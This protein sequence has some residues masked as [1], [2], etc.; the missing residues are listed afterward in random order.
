MYPLLLTLVWVWQVLIGAIFT[1]RLRL[2]NQSFIKSIGIRYRSV[3][4]GVK[5]NRMDDLGA[6]MPPIEN[7]CIYILRTKTC[8]KIN[9]I[10]TQIQWKQVVPIIYAIYYWFRFFTCLRFSADLGKLIL[11]NTSMSLFLHVNNLHNFTGLV[12]VFKRLSEASKERVSEV[13]C[14][15]NLKA[16][17]VFTE[18]AYK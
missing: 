9:L 11:W 13:S 4:P 3:A 12:I 17:S 10:L 8:A 16:L 18:F 5:K 15:T 7:N 14:M 6:T 2:T 1:R